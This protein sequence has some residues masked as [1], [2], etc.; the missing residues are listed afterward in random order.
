MKVRDVMTTNVLTIDEFTTVADAIKIMQDNSLSSLIIEPLDKKDSYGIV[1]EIDILYKV[2]AKGHHPQQL[3]VRDIMTRPCIE[4]KPNLNIKSAAQL[5]AKAGI[6]Y[7]PIVQKKLFSPKKLLGVISVR[8]LIIK[9]DIVEQPH[10][11]QELSKIDDHKEKVIQDST[12]QKLSQPPKVEMTDYQRLRSQGAISTYSTRILDKMS[13]EE[14]ATSHSEFVEQPNQTEDYREEVTQDSKKQQS[15]PGPKDQL[16]DYQRLRAQGSISRYS[17]RILDKMTPDD[18]DTSQADFV[19]QSNQTEDYS[20]EATQDSKKQKSSP[21]PK[22][23]LTDYQRLRAQG[24]IS[25][26]STRILNKMPQEK[27]DKD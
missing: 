16:T 10:K 21:D 8:D 19:E 20:K 23:Q 2:V 26:Y 3:C 5:F 7:A 24:S 15:S 13:P 18:S 17:T 12:K 11:S 6:F 9:S 14:S 25:R 1:T 4:V 22:E 27:K